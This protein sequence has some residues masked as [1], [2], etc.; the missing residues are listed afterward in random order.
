MLKD[1]KDGN[2]DDPAGRWLNTGSNWVDSI[3]KI[4]LKMFEIYLGL[5]NAPVSTLVSLI[6]FKL[7]FTSIERFLWSFTIEKDVLSFISETFFLLDKAGLFRI[8]SFGCLRPVLN[9][10]CGATFS[11]GGEVSNLGSWRKFGGFEK[12]W[13]IWLII[14]LLN[15]MIRKWTAYW[16]TTAP[17]PYNQFVQRYFLIWKGWLRVFFYDCHRVKL[18]LLS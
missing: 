4:V 3:S 5:T 18:S 14:L 10:D 8:S 9:S 7:F 15:L 13:A 2:P 6:S 1:N 12:T 11:P 16:S 17:K